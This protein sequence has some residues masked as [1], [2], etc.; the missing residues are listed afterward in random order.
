ML[1]FSFQSE[2]GF[3]KKKKKEKKNAVFPGAHLIPGGDAIQ[4]TRIQAQ[5]G[6][7]CDLH[8]HYHLNESADRLVQGSGHHLDS[9]PSDLYPI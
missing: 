2:A 8:T 9:F 5:R 1:I 3:K 6:N 4:V 7:R